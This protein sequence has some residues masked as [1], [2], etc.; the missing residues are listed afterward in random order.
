MDRVEFGEEVGVGVETDADSVDEDDGKF[1]GGGVFAVP[2][3]RVL[4]W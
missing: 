1:S 2:V 3:G 4:N